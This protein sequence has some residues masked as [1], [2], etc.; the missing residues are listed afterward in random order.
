MPTITISNESPY[1]EVPDGRKHVIASITRM[2]NFTINS[3]E[4]LL[5]PNGY[6]IR[7]FVER[8]N[9]NYPVGQMDNMFD[10]DASEN[11]LAFQDNGAT[12]YNVGIV[13]LGDTVF[14]VVRIDRN[15]ISPIR[16]K[17]RITYDS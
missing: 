16:Y 12:S 1:Q 13:Y 3:I 14:L 6:G 8:N 9:A 2:W 11:I 17:F 4:V 15:Q 10:W 5:N 7:T